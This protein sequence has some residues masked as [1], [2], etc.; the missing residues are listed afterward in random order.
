MLIMYTLC[1]KNRPVSESIHQ[2]LSFW[3]IKL[4]AMTNTGYVTASH[5]EIKNNTC[6]RCHFCVVGY[7]EKLEYLDLL[8]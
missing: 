8:Q 7:Y 3:Y 6:Y 4:L 1:G 5:R 2:D